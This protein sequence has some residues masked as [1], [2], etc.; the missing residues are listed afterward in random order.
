MLDVKLECKGVPSHKI[1][2]CLDRFGK[3]FPL[4]YKIEVEGKK[5]VISFQIASVALLNDLSRR[6]KHL[7]NIDFEY[8]LIENDLEGGAEDEDTQ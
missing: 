2:N 5:V 3:K 1:A 8:T 4:K 6:I 7:K